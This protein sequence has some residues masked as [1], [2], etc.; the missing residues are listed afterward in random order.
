M[1]KIIN[2]GDCAFLAEVTFMSHYAGGE[3]EFVLFEKN[4]LLYAL[5]GFPSATVASCQREIALIAIAG[6]EK[7]ELFMLN[8][9]NGV[10]RALAHKKK[11]G[12]E[13]SFAASRFIKLFDSQLREYVYKLSP[14]VVTVLRKLGPERG[15]SYRVA[16]LD[17]GPLK[18]L[19]RAFAARVDETHRS[20]RDPGW[21]HDLPSPVRRF[22]EEPN[23]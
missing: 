16:S 20:G 10:W 23:G 12:K 4:P 19:Y 18:I 5:P 22:L 3:E 7:L 9:V 21:P 15:A 17:S 14:D 2:S 11:F 8:A 13:M 6:R 1:A